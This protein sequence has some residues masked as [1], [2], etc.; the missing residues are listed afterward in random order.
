LKHR[1]HE[2]WFDLRSIATASFTVIAAAKSGNVKVEPAWEE[3]VRSIIATLAFWEE[4]AVDLI[5]TRS[6]LEESMEEMS[7]SLGRGPGVR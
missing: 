4:E 7:G 5:M 3:R 2:I 1:H 6:V